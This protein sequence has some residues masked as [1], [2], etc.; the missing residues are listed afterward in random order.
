MCGS[1]LSCQI[2][3]IWCGNEIE[4]TISMTMQTFMALIW[5]HFGYPFE[6]PIVLLAIQM[7]ALCVM[8]PIG[9][10]SLSSGSLW[11]AP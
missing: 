1:L 7:D 2:K 11:A 5:L 8:L 4:N 3:N 6:L 9:M 10:L